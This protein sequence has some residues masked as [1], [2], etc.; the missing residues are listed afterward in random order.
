MTILRPVIMC[1]GAGARLW[2]FSRQTFP[3]QLLPI[4]G[5]RSMLQ[6]TAAR[7]AS[8]EFAPPLIVTSEEHGQIAERQLREIGI[9]P[10]AVLL[11]PVA[12]NTAAVAALA[13]EW[14]LAGGKD[15]LLL[16]LP[17]DHFILDRAAFAAAVRSGASQANDGG[18]VLFGVPAFEANTQYGYIEAGGAG[19]TGVQPV[20]G[21][22]EK[23]DA[24]TAARYCGSGRHYWNAGIFLTQ[25]S[26]LLGELSAYLPA[27]RE[28]IAR[29]FQQRVS[30]G[31]F[32]RPNPQA[33]SDL[34]SI[35]LDCGVMQRTKRAFV[36]PV[37]MGWSDVGSWAAVWSSSA[38]DGNNNVTV[39]DVLTV[40]TRNSL[41]R[42]DGSAVV[43]TIGLQDI[44]VVGT[45][46]AILVAPLRR[47]DEVKDVVKRLATAGRSCATRPPLDGVP[48]VASST[49]R[50]AVETIAPQWTPAL[51]ADPI[52]VEEYHGHD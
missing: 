39:G 38:K 45:K 36:I 24:A 7:V 30:N 46:D 18:I 16:L 20:L 27:T 11:E 25:A 8:D 34:D 40:D 37:E 26:T 50:L 17:S 51:Q 49:D 35:S 31:L 32:V 47:S 41:V 9:A 3:K 48:I 15:E 4:V 1:G 33:F 21:F 5:E 29:G 44:V 19:A 22:A 28:A 42:S 6:E 14:A 52:A 23:P 13:A 12:R 10:A 43:V 2:P